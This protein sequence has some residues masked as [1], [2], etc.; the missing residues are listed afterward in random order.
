MQICVCKTLDQKTRK[1]GWTAVCAVNHIISVSVYDCTW[2]RQRKP[3]SKDGCLNSEKHDQRNTIRKTHKQMPL[4]TY[5]IL[6]EEFFLK[7]DQFKDNWLPCTVD[8]IWKKHESRGNG[9]IQIQDSPR[10]ALSL[11]FHPIGFYSYD[12]IS[13][14]NKHLLMNW[15]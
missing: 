6:T 9:Q 12:L 2:M 1:N 10:T 15:T 3:W 11:A 8:F 14:K 4:S 5:Y 13:N 7:T